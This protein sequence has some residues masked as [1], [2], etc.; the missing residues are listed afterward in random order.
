MSPPV[1]EK[2]HV[3]LLLVSFISV[4]WN[5]CGKQ[6]LHLTD[7]PTHPED[8]VYTFN[9][10]N[11]NGQFPIPIMFYL[12]KNCKEKIISGEQ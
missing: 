3:E 6:S 11:C 5:A 1:R 10:Y 4:Q 7:N 9:V 8:Y 12:S 2:P